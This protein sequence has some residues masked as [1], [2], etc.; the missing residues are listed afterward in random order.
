MRSVL[1]TLSRLSPLFLA[2]FATGALLQICQFLGVSRRSVAE[3]LS[4]A[5]WPILGCAVAL[6]LVVLLGLCHESGWIPRKRTPRWIVDILDRLTNKEALT[7]LMSGQADPVTI[8]SAQ[9][10]KALT[11]RVIGQ[12]SV[13]EDLANQIRRRMALMQRG[14]PIGV[15]LFAGPPGTGKTYLGKR[16]A[17]ELGRKLIHLDM[18][19]FSSGSMGATQLFGSPPGF[20]GSDKYGKLTSALLDIPDAVVLLDEIEKAHPDVHKK[21][22]TAWNDGFITEAS[23][24]KQVSTI[25]AIFI[26]TTNAAIDALKEL[27]ARYVNDPDELRRTSVAALQRAG[28]APEVLSRIDRVFVFHSLV[29]LDV[30]RVAALEIEQMIG[31]YGLS[32][33]E[34][35]IDPHVLLAVMQRQERLGP[36]ASA[37]DVVRVIEEAISDSLIDAKQRKATSVAL[38]HDGAQII[39]QPVAL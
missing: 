7:R 5:S 28:F 17:S 34:G 1:S 13:C 29:G 23:D 20:Q 15:F 10:T 19:Q 4:A 37:R 11:A 31:A 24:G 16:L 32:V 33:A 21:F 6:W 9:L 3:A 12:D 26:L 18:S 39:A 14:K 8:D 30:A 36:T 35:G 25:G 2:I 22:L 27:T 38:V